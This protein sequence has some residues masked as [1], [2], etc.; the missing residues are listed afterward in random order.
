MTAIVECDRYSLPTMEAGGHD[1]RRHCVT[2][3]HVCVSSLSAL[4]QT[5]ANAKCQYNL[6]DNL[7]KVASSCIN[8][9]N[10]QNY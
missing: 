6:S 9:L 1:R 10:Q 5:G 4:N 8:S 7:L 3:K 2:K